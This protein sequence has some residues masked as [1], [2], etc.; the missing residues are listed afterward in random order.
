MMQ[1]LVVG[2]RRGSINYYYSNERIDSIMA[3]EKEIWC[4]VITDTK[5][6]RGNGMN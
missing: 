2:E 6:E 3:G 4:F 1:L 5:K